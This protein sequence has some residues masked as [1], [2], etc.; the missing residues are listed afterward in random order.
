[1]ERDGWACFICQ[2]KEQTL[3]VHHKSYMDGR[4]P[5]EYE[6]EDLVTLCESC[7]SQIHSV[8][9]DSPEAFN[10]TDLFWA[11]EGMWRI[12]ILALQDE[13]FRSLGD[14]SG[15]YAALLCPYAIKIVR[16]R[17]AEG[18]NAAGHASWPIIAK[19]F[20]LA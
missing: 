18:V 1:M 19:F 6:D 15:K 17:C 16:Q 3:N 9:I 12:I 11:T 20:G 5:W 8:W 10:S 7:H 13:S 4:E 14:S 2:N